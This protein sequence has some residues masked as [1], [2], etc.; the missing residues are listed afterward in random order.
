MPR[1][2]ILSFTSHFFDVP[3]FWPESKGKNIF[4][5]SPLGGWDSKYVDSSTKSISNLQLIL[6]FVVGESWELHSLAFTYLLQFLL[7]G[8]SPHYG[9]LHILSSAKIEKEESILYFF[10]YAAHPVGL[11]VPMELA[12]LCSLEGWVS[13]L[14]LS[15]LWI[16]NVAYYFCK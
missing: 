4:Q 12:K 1:K 16:K 6:T 13:N 14:S 7:H 9:M 10:I 5:F 3:L 11:M 2:H 8:L 15:F